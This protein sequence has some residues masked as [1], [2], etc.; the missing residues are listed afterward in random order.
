MCLNAKIEREKGEG[1]GQ[2]NIL[3]Q[4]GLMMGIAQ[5]E[6]RQQG[7]IELGRFVFEEPSSLPPRQNNPKRK[8]EGKRR[9]TLHYRNT[10]AA[11]S[12]FASQPTK[13]H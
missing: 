10:K 11:Q 4:F 2:G 13:Q 8:K 1:G 7:I 3:A 6:G 5:S 9:Q 12:A